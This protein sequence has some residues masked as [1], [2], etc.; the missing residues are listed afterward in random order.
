M[1]KHKQILKE[2]QLESGKLMTD[3]QKAKCNGIIHTAAAASGAAGAIPIP[4]ADAIP[5]TAAQ[6]TMVIALGKVFEVN[7]TEA[8]AKTV[9]TAVAA[10]IVGRTVASA[11]L[12]FIPIAGWIASAALAAGVTEAIGWIV[13]NDFAKKY[14]NEYLNQRNEQIRRE[15]DVAKE[16]AKIFEDSEEKSNDPGKYL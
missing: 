7:L 16:K 14:K 2:A 9:L 15:R 1:S 10:P 12:K 13:A 3:S 8:A 5:I 4:I 11:G 6:V